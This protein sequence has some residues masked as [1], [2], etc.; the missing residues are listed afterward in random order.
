M[1]APEILHTAERNLP[2]NFPFGHVHGRQGTPWWRAARQVRRRLQEAPQH[3][4]GRTALRSVVSVFIFGL[5]FVPRDQAY[6]CGDVVGVDQQQATLWI[7]SVSAPGHA[8][9]VPGHSKRALD[10]GRRV[11]AF[12]AVTF[13][14]VATCFAIL[15]SWTPSLVSCKALWNEGG[16]R[17][18]ERLRR[19]GHFAG[20]VALRHGAFLDRENGLARVAIEHKE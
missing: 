20:H 9:E 12:V 19:R 4:V 5:H 14:P 7:E 3:G 1:R 16:R 6:P 2:P 8:S 17:Q 10:A 18:R 11:D 13:N 15:G